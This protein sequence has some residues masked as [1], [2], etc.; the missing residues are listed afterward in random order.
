MALGRGWQQT[1]LNQ[2]VGLQGLVSEKT[3]FQTQGAVRMNP[4]VLF[5]VIFEAETR[6]LSHTKVKTN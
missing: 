4:S 1:S 5:I 3:S 2:C 6:P